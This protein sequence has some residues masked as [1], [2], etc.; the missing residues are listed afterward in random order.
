MR[1]R[2]QHVTTYTYTETV[3]VC[4]N[5]VMLTPRE[6]PG[7]FCEQQRLGVTPQP[8]AIHRRHDAFGNVLH[9]FSIEEPH[10][11][12]RISATSQVHV[13]PAQLPAPDATLPWETVRD[14]V[15]DGTERHWTDAIPFV[16]DSP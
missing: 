1:Y 15:L 8:R 3:P 13:K 6:A 11:R 9:G 12:L 4:H 7:A 16:F 10:Q 14:T 5:V 2:I